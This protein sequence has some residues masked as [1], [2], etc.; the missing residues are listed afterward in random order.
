MYIYIYSKRERERERDESI[1]SHVSAIDKDVSI[2][3]GTQHYQKQV[4]VEG[5]SVDCKFGSAF[6]S[7]GSLRLTM[8][9]DPASVAFCK[10]RH[11]HLMFALN[12]RK[13][14]W[15][16]YLKFIFPSLLCVSPLYFSLVCFY[17]L[18]N[19]FFFIKKKISSF[20]LPFFLSFFHSFINQI[21][22]IVSF[23]LFKD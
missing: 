19:C 6:Y 8:T 17:F 18:S 4:R 7:P 1:S 14:L 10:R 23:S 15:K 5:D 2:S 11:F 13:F 16:R 21:P 12:S 20:F 22:W 3:S 9:F